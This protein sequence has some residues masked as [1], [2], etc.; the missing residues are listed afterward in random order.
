MLSFADS[1]PQLLTPRPVNGCL[2]MAHDEIK[3]V[4]D[5]DEEVS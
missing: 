5:L 1:V 4:D 3:E 2:T